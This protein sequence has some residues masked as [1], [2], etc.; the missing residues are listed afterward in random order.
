MAN[1]PQNK[2]L[3]EQMLLPHKSKVPK[4][5]IARQL[6]LSKNTVNPIWPKQPCAMKALK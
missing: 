6:G 1:T 5:D 3:V 2:N 4:K